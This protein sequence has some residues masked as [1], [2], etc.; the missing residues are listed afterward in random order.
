MNGSRR[1]EKGDFR[2]ALLGSRKVPDEGDHLYPLIVERKGQYY[3]AAVWMDPDWDNEPLI[4]LCAAAHDTA[5]P[6]RALF[7]HFNRKHNHRKLGT[8]DAVPD[9]R[10]GLIGRMVN[11]GISRL[12]EVRQ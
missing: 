5:K 3:T 9:E 4:F 6:A 11:F 7:D 10:A 12:F 8:F 1:N 2:V